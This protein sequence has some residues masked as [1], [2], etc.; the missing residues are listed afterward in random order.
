VLAEIDP[1][2]AST[3]QTISHSRHRAADGDAQVLVDY[4]LGPGR[5]SDAKLGRIG[6]AVCQHMVG[7]IE[8]GLI[9]CE[10]AAANVLVFDQTSHIHVEIGGKR[11]AEGKATAHF[12]ASGDKLKTRWM[13]PEAIRRR[14]FSEKSDVF[15]FGILLWELWSHGSYPF[16]TVIDDFEVALRIMGGERLARPEGCPQAVYATMQR[17]W[18]AD[19][20]SRPTFRELQH[21]LSNLDASQCVPALA[22]MDDGMNLVEAAARRYR[23][24][25][26]L[27]FALLRFKG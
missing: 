22:A 18:V 4:L 6:L 10:L 5:A 15:A 20:V 16:S 17:C 24:F 2:G 7:M 14:Q 12:Y 25:C 9:H 11:L 1:R 3:Q 26:A 8:S 27:L 21:V 23:G 13:A 19:P